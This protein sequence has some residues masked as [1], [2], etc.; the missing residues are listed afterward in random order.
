MF[1]GSR[2]MPTP[3]GTLYTSNITPDRETGIG[4][5]SAEQFCGA[6]HSGRFSECGQIYPAKPFGSKTKVTRDDSYAIFAYLR[7][8]PPVTQPNRT[9]DLQFPYNNR[10]LLLGWRTLVFQ[11]GEFNPDPAK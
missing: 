8:A 9:H 10:S 11:E 7:A 2:P 4:T 6:M 3:L 1:A 5:W